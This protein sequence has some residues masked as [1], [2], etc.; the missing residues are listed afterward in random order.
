[1]RGP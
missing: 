1:L